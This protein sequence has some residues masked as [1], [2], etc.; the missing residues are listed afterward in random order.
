M[1]IY[2][3]GEQRVLFVHVPKTGGTTVERLFRTAGWAEQLRETHKANPDTFALR[4][5]S[6][7]H[8]HAAVLAELYDLTRFD[9]TFLLTRD[10]IARFRSEYL[11]RNRSDPRAEAAAV[12]EW[13][14]HAFE[15]WREDPYAFD[16][17][18]RPQHEFLVERAVVYRL[19]DGLGSI[20]RDL[21]DRLDAQL[22]EQPP[23]AMSSLK[24]AGVPSSAVE[25]SAGLDRA[26]REFYAAD[27]A[28]FDY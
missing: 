20:L 3:R 10:P 14:R 24:R 23:R 4:R 15:R 1:P 13:A 26:L 22:S 18:L 6:P 12:E 27:F 17:H 16:N 8:Y 25:V 7:Q 28:Q 11:M 9:L 21:N 19:E 5:C 2:S